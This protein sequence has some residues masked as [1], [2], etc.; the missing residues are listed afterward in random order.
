MIDEKIFHP[1]AEKVNK[2]N[3]IEVTK[4]VMLDH[5]T[6][7]YIT[8]KYDSIKLSSVSMDKE[9]WNR[10]KKLIKRRDLEYRES[11]FYYKVFE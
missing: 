3:A 4:Y 5:Y 7:K 1:T 2:A 10:F 6:I 11:K 8:K 9:H